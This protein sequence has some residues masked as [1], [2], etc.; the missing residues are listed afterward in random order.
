[1]AVQQR[2]NSKTRTAKRRTHYKLTAPA[3][4]KCPQCGALKRQHRL[5]AECG[6]YNGVK[7]A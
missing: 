5:C 7:V 4:V 1:M 3:L 2:R 6:F